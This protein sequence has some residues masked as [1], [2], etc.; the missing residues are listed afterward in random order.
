MKGLVFGIG[1]LIDNHAFG[2]SEG[3]V[4]YEGRGKLGL[5]GEA[6]AEFFDADQEIADAELGVDQSQMAVDHFRAVVRDVE[7]RLDFDIFAFDVELFED[8][9][10]EQMRDGDAKGFFHAIVGIDDKLLVDGLDEFDDGLPDLGRDD[11]EIYAVG[12]PEGEILRAGVG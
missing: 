5:I 2:V 12:R 8:F 9:E 7:H 10:P 1:Q 6:G 11:F 4:S 3:I